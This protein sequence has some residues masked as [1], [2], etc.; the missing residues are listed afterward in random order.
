MNA[1]AAARNNAETVRTRHWLRGRLSRLPTNRSPH[2][3]PFWGVQRA[4]LAPRAESCAEASEL[5]V[6]GSLFHIACFGEWGTFSLDC[7]W[8]VFVIFQVRHFRLAGLR[9]HIFGRM[10]VLSEHG[11]HGCLVIDLEKTNPNPYCFLGG[12]LLSLEV[13]IGLPVFFPAPVPSSTSCWRLQNLT[14]RK[15]RL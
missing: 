1:I 4:A 6:I 8:E 7:K 5:Q 2:D 11:N 10:L 9:L 12:S 13:I 15:G 14:L 3:C